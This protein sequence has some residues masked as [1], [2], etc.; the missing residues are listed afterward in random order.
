M[1]S[2]LPTH[3]ER[4]WDRGTEDREAVTERQ[5]RWRTSKDPLRSSPDGNDPMAKAAPENH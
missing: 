2:A 3:L 4:S 5:E 1:G